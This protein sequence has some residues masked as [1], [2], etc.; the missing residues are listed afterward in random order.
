MSW[1]IF[2]IKYH[3]AL[4][5]YKR[6]RS[7]NKTPEPTGGKSSAN[8]LTFVVQKHQASHL[9]YDFRLEM[10]GVLKSWAVPKGPSMKHTEKRL[11]M[12]VED[13]PFDY[14]DFEGI[15]PEGNY[16]AGSVIVWDEGW[17]EPVK[18]LKDKKAREHEL[19][20]QFFSGSM[21]IKLH[22]KKLKGIFTLIK[23]AERGASSWLLTKIKDKDA[24]TVDITQKDKSVIS[25]KSVDEIAKDTNANEWQSNRSSK[26]GTSSVNKLIKKGKR[27]S[28]P[29]RIEP[30]LASLSKNVSNSELYQYEVKWDGYRIISFVK[31]GN[32][33]LDSRGHENYTNRY[34]LVIEALQTLNRD[35]V[36]DGEIVVFDEEGKPNFNMA[37][38]YNGK[39]TPITY[40]VF[41]IIYIDGYDVRELPLVER[42]AILQQI[43]KGNN[44][45]KFSESFDDGEGLF[46]L[47]QE[48]AWEGIVAKR[49]DSEYLEDDRS[50]RWMKYPVKKVDEFVIGGWAD[51]DKPG[52]PFRSILFGAY[53][54]GTLR[55]L[56]RSGGGFKEKEMPGILKKL[57]ALKIKKSPFINEVLDDKG[58][59]IHWVK[60]LLVANFE[61]SE[62]TESGR[63]RKPAT[64][65]G[66]RDD[67]K[68]KDVIIPVVKKVNET[69]TNVIIDAIPKKSEPAKK[70]AGTEHKRSRN[71]KQT[72]LNKDSGWQKVD[73]EQRGAEWQEFKVENCT[74]PVHSL[75]KELWE[76]IPKGRLLIYYSEMADYILPYIEDRPQSLN[77]KLNGIGAPR[78]IIKDMENRQPNCASV[79]LD[80]RRVRK[81]GK[82]NEIDYLICNNLATLIYMIDLGCVDINPWASRQQHIEQPDYLWFDLDP[83]IPEGLKG[84]QLLAMEEK[85]FEKAIGVAIAAKKVL[86]KHRLISFIKTSGKTGL[87]IY[88]PFSGFTFKNARSLAYQLADE[89][90]NVVSKISTRQESKDL[91]GENVY[92]DAGQNDYADTL[93]APYSIRPY[94]QPLVSTPLEWKEVKKGLDRYAFTMDT[95]RKRIEKKGDLWKK[96]NDKKII[97]TNNRSLSKL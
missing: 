29:D 5:E 42:K 26:S 18:G 69:A 25:G 70:K 14:K 11:A 53:D 38:L 8:R 80:N 83:T 97:L 28:M 43:V 66:F 76:D 91:R 48:K 51:S 27:S 36:I 63:I 44:I 81:A 20:K 21:K 24:L 37:Q 78:T 56:G 6:K 57:K 16:G 7:F 10:R 59:V 92:I 96:L 47:M 62:M 85:G 17:Y 19:L 90:H 13:H 34:P 87:H 41:D 40:Y 65:K 35:V 89:M 45:I 75:D 79:F 3:M 82:R 55:W 77:L 64:F 12:L 49:K 2:G 93:A 50:Y 30:M 22:G 31:N 88:L 58:A 46:E 72:Y 86:D 73:E 33:R 4:T 94:H 54:K 9:H 95:I 32:V 61:Y 23:N 84:K 60:P 71:K 39:T 74:I 67:K 1:R 52:R 68:P 15:I